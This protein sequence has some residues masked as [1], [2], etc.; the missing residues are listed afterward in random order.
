MKLSSAARDVRI[1]CIHQL[2]PLDI[3]IRLGHI[4]LREITNVHSC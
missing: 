2:L 4:E 1:L 3:E